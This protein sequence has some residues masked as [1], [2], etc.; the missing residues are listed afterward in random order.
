MSELLSIGLTHIKIGAIAGDGGMGT[1]LASVGNTYE[2]TCT[3]TQEDSE[4]TEFY[5]EEVDD[6]I[7]VMSKKGKTILE[8]AIVDWT[9]S[10]LVTV[11]GGTVDGTGSAAK[12][13]APSDIP[14]IEKS[15]QIL[16]KKDVLI[17]IPRAKIEGKLD[18]NFSKKEIAL[19]RIKA[20]VLTPTK[21]AEA[22]IYVSEYTET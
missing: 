8:W 19:V 12:W 20:T 11:L 14:D 2:G 18:A 1:A 22:P 10:T 17:E 9:P 13:S 7:E 6:P 4:M 16:T 21:E 5:A 15:I 3:L